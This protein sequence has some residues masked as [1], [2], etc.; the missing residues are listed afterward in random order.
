ME[1]R[2]FFSMT[3]DQSLIQAISGPYLFWI[4]IDSWGHLIVGVN[5]TANGFTLVVKYDRS[6]GRH[7]GEY[8][9]HMPGPNYEEIG[10]KGEFLY[11]TIKDKAKIL[12]IMGALLQGRKRDF[13]KDFI[14]YWNQGL[15]LVE[16]LDIVSPGQRRYSSSK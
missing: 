12:S 5:D 6:V 4:S 15:D 8:Q 13:P 16:K 3:G 14:E 11:M 2:W 10:K 9:V 7:L 1:A